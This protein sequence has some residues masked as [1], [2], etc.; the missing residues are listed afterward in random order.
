MRDRAEDVVQLYRV[1]DLEAAG[2]RLG[3]QS[4]GSTKCTSSEICP[5]MLTGWILVI[6]PGFDPLNMQQGF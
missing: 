4:S 2:N 5:W 6:N 1:A 3:A